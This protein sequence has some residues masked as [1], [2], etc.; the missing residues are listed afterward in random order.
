MPE[1]RETSDESTRAEL[2]ILEAGLRGLRRFV[3]EEHSRRTGEPM[4]RAE[5]R[6]WE[7]AAAE[8]EEILQ[9]FQRLDPPLA[10]KLESLREPPPNNEPAT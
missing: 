2:A 6:L 7:L 9:R 1:P 8:F 3:L 5:Q 10:R 4:N